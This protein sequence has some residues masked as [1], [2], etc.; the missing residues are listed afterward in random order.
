[1]AQLDRDIFRRN[2]V[3]NTFHPLIKLL[4]FTLK[5]SLFP[6]LWCNIFQWTDFLTGTGYISH[7]E[8]CDLI[9]VKMQED[10]DEKELKMM[11]HILDKDKRGEVLSPW[12]ERRFREP[13]PKETFTTLSRPY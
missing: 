13:H 7:Q 11:F 9:R 6:S 10:E 5:F 12:H 2:T 1:M 3:Y 4:E 8:F